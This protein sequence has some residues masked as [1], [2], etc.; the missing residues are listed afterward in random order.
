MPS[1]EGKEVKL[2]LLVKGD[3]HD[4]TEFSVA[5]IDPASS[6]EVEV[7]EPSPVSQRAITQFPLYI[8][9]PKGAPTVNRRGTEQAKAGE[10]IL[11]TTHPKVKRMQFS[12]QFA[13]E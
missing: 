11:E 2:L 7:G 6:L 1:D 12:V 3:H 13:V 5:S 4:K 8:R 10:V 9:V